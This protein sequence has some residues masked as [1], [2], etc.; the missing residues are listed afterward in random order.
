MRIVCM[1]NDAQLP[2]MKNMLNSAM[3]VGIPMNLFHCYILNNQKEI[4]IYGT[5]QFN[6]ITLKKLEVIK[7]NMGMDREILWVDNDI[8][9]FENCL[10]DIMSK[11]G[12]FVM[13][14]DL[15]GACTG[16][17]L[18]R[19]GYFSSS[20]LQKSIDWLTKSTNKSTNDQHA[21]NRVYPQVVGIVVTKLS[22]EEYPNG[23]I[24]FNKQVTA[25]A[26]MVHCNYLTS[27]NEKVQR[28]KDHGLWDESDTAFL[29]TNRYLI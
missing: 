23:E 17:F 8:V 26:K 15:W 2:M 5:T 25:K 3:K 10:N 11:R 22:T 21:F 12:N 19:S 29:L 13:Q 24:Y 27:T 9:F 1:T 4:A 16:F 28:F 18:A 14:D 20:V 6:S 7:M